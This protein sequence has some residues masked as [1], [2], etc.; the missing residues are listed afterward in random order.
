MCTEQ[1]WVKDL[2]KHSMDLRGGSNQYCLQ[3]CK[4]HCNGL[5]SRF[6]ALGDYVKT[7]I[8][9]FII[10]VG[11]MCWRQSQF[12]H[13]C[14]KSVISIF[15]QSISQSLLFTI[16]LYKHGNSKYLLYAVTM[17][18]PK[19]TNRPANRAPQLQS[20]NT[21]SR[22]VYGT[23]VANNIIASTK[24]RVVTKTSDVMFLYS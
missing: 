2:P 9:I 17:G 11:R 1:L 14:V 24:P 16:G 20:I 10:T 21:T 8:L 7:V 18:V 3:S 19:G 4:R 13:E 6:L 22:V 12:Q 23:S 15:N 5:T